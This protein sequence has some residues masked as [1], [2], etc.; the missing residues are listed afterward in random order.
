MLSPVLAAVFARAGLRLQPEPEF[1]QVETGEA[2]RAM[3]RALSPLLR[4]AVEAA[5]DEGRP[6]LWTLQPPIVRLESASWQPW[7]GAV[8]YE[9]SNQHLSRRYWD[10]DDQRARTVWRWSRQGDDWLRSGWAEYQS[11][12]TE[13]WEEVQVDW[14]S[15]EGVPFPRGLGILG[16][17]DFEGRRE[18]LSL[19]L[20]Q[21]RL[22]R[23]GLAPLEVPEGPLADRVREQWE[24]FY[25][26]PDEAASLSGQFDIRLPGTD[27]VWLGER[28]VR[29]QF[30]LHGFRG[31]RWSLWD[32]DVETDR[33]REDA[34]ALASALED[35]LRLFVGREL[36]GREPFDVAFAGAR[37]QEEED[38]VVRIE[39]GPFPALR[40]GE[41]RL[42]S[43]F[44]DAETE[45]RFSWRR[46]GG[47]W[48][49]SAIET[50]GERIEYDWARLGDGWFWP[51]RVEMIEV[52]GDD[53]GPERLSLDKL[54]VGD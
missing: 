53:W 34:Q 41:E 19:E 43:V 27:G 16:V 36:G 9:L 18:R 33:S 24:S 46:L 32:I 50:A 15:V 11:F 48:V 49:P 6:S 7:K 14:Q 44:V 28:R 1:E 2:V 3:E 37:L 31:T 23:D 30:S 51:R 5:L 4:P 29:G 13:V 45:R 42:Q 52:F 35:R 40:L 54:E 26:Y 39:G 20:T 17:K 22:D 38:G 25:A 12:D 10:A 47:E 21:V 8:H